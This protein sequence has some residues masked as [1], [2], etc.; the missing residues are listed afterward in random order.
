MLIEKKLQQALQIALSAIY[1]QNIPLEEILTSPTPSHFIGT[2]TFT[3]FPL[4]KILQ[5]KPEEIATHLGKWLIQ[6]TEFITNYQVVKGFLNVQIA[7]KVWLAKLEE[8]ALSNHKPLSTTPQTIL[9]EFSSPNTNKP[10][11]LGHLRNNF[12]GHALAQMM[13]A[14]GHKVYKVNVVNDRGIHICKSMLA[15]KQWGNSDTPSN[16]SIKGDHFVGKYYVLFEKAYQ[17]QVKELV[18]QVGDEEKARKQA[19]LLQA[20]Q[21]MLQQWEAGDK[22]VIALWEKM[23][24]WVYEGFEATYKK[25]G[26]QFDKTY[27]ESQTYLN[28]KILVTEGLQKNIFYQEEDGSIWTDLHA[29]GL[30]KK[31][32]LRANGTSV[33]I[34]QDMGLIDERY[35]TYK[36]DKH[37]YVV[38]NEQNYHFKVLFKV[39]KQLK[40]PYATQLEHLS[41]GMV[42]LPSGKMKSRE[43]TAVDADDLIDEMIGVATKQTEVLGKTKGFSKQ[44][45]DKLHKTIAM[46]ALK[47][48][49]LK[50]NPQKNILFDP[51]ASIDLQ[52]NTGPFIQYTHARICSM[53]SGT[54][55]HNYTFSSWTR[56]SEPLH[57]CEKE[58]VIQLTRFTDQLHQA[59]QTYNPALLCQYAYDL[60]K[61]YNRLYATLPVLHEKD[62]T[63]RAKRLYLSKASAHTLNKTMNLLGITLPERM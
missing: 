24:A 28:G 4:A 13:Q 3:T 16:T 47:Y 14:L 32:L 53:L 49:L 38:G 5:Q 27:H 17:K 48:F 6:H 23:N 37:I 10:L 11:H 8:L 7:D 26:I 42:D 39:L 21:Q 33:Y 63:I 36:F 31:L 52:G 51:K 44:E 62:E 45:L 9:I 19:P 56:T 50:V 34:T 57:P 43:G 40:K 22:E 18:Q 46:G 35:Q 59:T 58:V 54:K 2:H 29:E 55:N 60:A 12:L 30:D 25:M 61:S 41:Y 15:Y 20:A 1:N